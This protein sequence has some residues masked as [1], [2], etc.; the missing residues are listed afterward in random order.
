M[1]G[2]DKFRTGKFKMFFVKLFGKKIII[3]NNGCVQKAYLF[4]RRF[5]IVYFKIL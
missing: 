4:R 1:V 3:L 5:Y 2:K